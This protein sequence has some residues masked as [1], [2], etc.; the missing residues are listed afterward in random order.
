VRAVRD[1]IDFSLITEGPLFRPVNRFDKILPSRLT[2]Q[3][4]AGLTKGAMR[5]KWVRSLARSRAQIR[6]LGV[7]SAPVRS[8][9]SEMSGAESPRIQ[10]GR[11]M[12][13][14]EEAADPRQPAK[15]G[16]ELRT[17]PDA[18]KLERYFSYS[19]MRRRVPTT[20]LYQIVGD[21]GPESPSLQLKSNEICRAV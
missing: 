2:D 13:C 19:A 14:K 4:L 3:S 17:A 21:I 5:P 6:R 20:S 7:L 11:F 8:P 16:P 10:R 9:A 12:P 1:W 15:R 18:Q